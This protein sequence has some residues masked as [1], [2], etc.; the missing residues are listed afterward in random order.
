MQSPDPIDNLDVCKSIANGNATM[1]KYHIFAVNVTIAYSSGGNKSISTTVLLNK[2]SG[3]SYGAITR[4][5]EYGYVGG[6]FL[7]LY[8]SGNT[9]KGE[10]K[11]Q[12]SIPFDAS[13]RNCT[14]TIN[15]IYGIV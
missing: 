12:T 3:T 9:I 13:P 7:K 11:F 2:N 14:V 1:A 5:T 8:F 10:G 6:I 4:S 15:S